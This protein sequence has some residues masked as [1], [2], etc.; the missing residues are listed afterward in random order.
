MSAV[1]PRS[2]GMAAGAVSTARQLGYAFG[3]AVL[4]SVFSA[5]S[6]RPAWR[7]GCDRRARARC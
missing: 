3:I 1:P 4:G 6:S 5:V 2:G 7:M